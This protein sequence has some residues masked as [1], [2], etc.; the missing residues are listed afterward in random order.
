MSLSPTIEEY[1]EAVYLL[2]SEGRPVLGARLAELLGVSAP[3]VTE[4][5]KR[6]RRDG[7]LRMDR[8]KQVHLTPSGQELAETLVRRHRLSE[9]LL[10]DVLGLEWHSVHAEACR[11]EHAIS[12]AVEARLVDVLAN[13]TTCPH[14][15]PIPG[16][17]AQENHIQEF[18]LSEASAGQNLLVRRVSQEAEL[19]GE[20]LAHLDRLGLRP[21]ARVEVQDVLKV[22]GTL[23]IR[24]QDDVT[25][26]GLSAASN[27]W[28]CTMEQ[29]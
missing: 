18:P 3:T 15:N 4:T 29:E 24:V 8:D 9:R 10:T 19:D 21:G 7:Y 27:L 16:T 25:T 26:L 17:A 5:L 1:L 23:T 14:G 2:Y 12:P 22:N 6:M 13:P 28:V 20:L 11:L